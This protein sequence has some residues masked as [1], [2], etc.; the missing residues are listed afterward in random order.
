MALE[1]EIIC[2]ANSRKLAGR[3]IAGKTK[4]GHWIR[5]VSMR[6]HEEVSENERQYDDGSDPQ[7][8]DVMKVALVRPKPNDFQPENWLLDH[9]HYWERK[10]RLTWQDVQAYV[11][12]VAPLWGVG[13]HSYN[14]R[15]FRVPVAGGATPK[16]S[17]RLIRVKSLMLRVFAPGS[18]FGNPKRRILGRFDYAGDV[19]ELWVTD[20]I[21]EREYLAKPDGKYQIDESL[22][23]VSLGEPFEGYYYVLIAAIIRPG[24]TR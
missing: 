23:T 21:Y 22:L 10:G 6:A 14:G 15:N 18:A 7:I 16:S 1:K 20:P 5:P 3:C 9:K 17:L 4:S 8:L 12:P 13:H 2:L 19:Y 24:N 11:D